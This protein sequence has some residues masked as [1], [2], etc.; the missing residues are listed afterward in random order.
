MDKRNYFVKN[1]RCNCDPAYLDI[2]MWPENDY[3]P[4]VTVCVYL[5]DDR[6]TVIFKTFE[7]NIV[8]TYTEPNSP[9]YLDSCVE[10]FVNFF[11]AQS[12]KYMNF[13]VNPAG[14]MLIGF[15]ESRE[16]RVLLD[17]DRSGFRIRAHS[18]KSFWSVEYDI[19][20]AFIEKHYGAAFAPENGMKWSANF[21]KCGD[22]TP[23]PH[24]Y[25]WN[26]I[27]SEKP[28]YHRPESFGRLTVKMN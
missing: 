10:F 24:Y 23:L 14:C 27:K 2:H 13:E 16:N 22:D 9:V 5:S 28:D 4:Y 20:F 26:R 3:K 8:S 25:V 17:D 11:P 6:L 18:E 19:P 1:G 7:E 12:A 15:G 21:Y